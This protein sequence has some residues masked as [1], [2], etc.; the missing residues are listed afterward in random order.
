MRGP[1][2]QS[3]APNPSGYPSACAKYCVAVQE[4][5][6][7]QSMKHRRM[8]PLKCSERL[9]CPARIKIFLL[10]QLNKQWNV[11]YIDLLLFLVQRFDLYHA[12]I[13][14]ELFGL[15][16]ARCPIALNSRKLPFR[17]LHTA[18]YVKMLA[19]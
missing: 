8:D 16:L 11:L 3:G 5:A 7:R 15:F 9:R 4:D 17:V 10:T 12:Y 2:C 6:T 18:R 1:I 13:G 14:C 19:K